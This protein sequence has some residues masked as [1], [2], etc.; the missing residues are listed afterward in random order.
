LKRYLAGAG[1]LYTSE[2]VE[3]SRAAPSARSR[4]SIAAMAVAT[5]VVANTARNDWYAEM[6]WTTAAARF[7]GHRD[8]T[9]TENGQLPSI[10]PSA[11]RVI[12]AKPKNATVTIDTRMSETMIFL[13]VCLIRICYNVFDLSRSELPTT[14]TLDPAMANPANTGERSQPKTGKSMPLASGIP[15]ML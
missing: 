9:T 14:E 7:C 2:P 3:N 12:V 15:T 5:P 13:W 10:P 11:A 1:G 8:S 6:W 4:A